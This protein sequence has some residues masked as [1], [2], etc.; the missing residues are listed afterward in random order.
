MN[1]DFEKIVRDMMKSG[2]SMKEVMDALGEMW[3]QIE[4]SDAEK[5]VSDWQKAIT[6]IFEE[7]WRDH[8]ATVD[9]TT[10]VEFLFCVLSRKHPEWSLKD[11]QNGVEVVGNV[12]QLIE[13][14]IGK[15]TP[16]MLSIMNRELDNLINKILKG[17][18]QEDTDS[19]KDPTKDKKTKGTSG[20]FFPISDDDAA[21]LDQFFRL[22][23]L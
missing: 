14:T 1:K 12:V 16:A 20:K 13:K 19:N 7:Q 11:I 9:I 10:I 18:Y 17:T 4:K 23:G 15:D 3:N 5:S 22:F 21:A 8:R 2:K 6:D